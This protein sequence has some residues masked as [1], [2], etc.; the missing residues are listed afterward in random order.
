MV[1]LNKRYEVLNLLLVTLFAVSIVTV[2]QG[3]KEHDII[4]VEFRYNLIVEIVTR[5]ENPNTIAFLLNK[6]LGEAYDIS[7]LSIEEIEDRI[8]CVRAVIET[9]NRRSFR[10]NATPLIGYLRKPIRVRIE[11]DRCFIV[12]VSPGS[13][14]LVQGDKLVIDASIALNY[15]SLLVGF[16]I[17]LGPQLVAASLAMMYLR[18]RIS[19]IRGMGYYVISRELSRLNIRLGLLFTVPPLTSLIA[20]LLATDLPAVLSILLNAEL[21]IGVIL[22]IMVFAAEMIVPIVYS[23]KYTAPLLGRRRLERREYSYAAGYIL[24]FVV[25][26]VIIFLLTAYMPESVSE[27]LVRLPPEPRILFWALVGYSVVEVVSYV[28]DKL[29]LSKLERPVEPW[30]VDMVDQLCKELGVVRFSRIRKLRT[31]GGELANAMVKGIFRRELIVTERLVK[32]LEPEELRA[33]IAHEI[34]HHKYRHIELLTLS[35]IAI[36]VLAYSIISR[37]HVTSYIERLKYSMLDLWNVV[38]LLAFMGIFIAVLTIAILAT[39]FISRRAEEKADYMVLKV[40]KD[41]RVFIRALAKIVV[42]DM[43]PM[44]PGKLVEKL[45]THPAPMKRILKVARRYNIPYDEVEG[46]IDSVVRE[47]ANKSELRS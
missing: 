12:H 37:M 35:W 45:G 36:L 39:R 29:V 44:E 18:R 16:A 14:F 9:W 42:A 15:D 5:T 23:M 25:A 47:L 22:T 20:T 4:M 30:I 31:I 46:I 7:D 8:Y 26:F 43:M 27:F 28:T 19:R 40:V 34:A 11:S 38:G 17:L 21:E 2:V 13:D 1:Y 41:P 24:S 32:L 33:I 6:T 3:W 10:W